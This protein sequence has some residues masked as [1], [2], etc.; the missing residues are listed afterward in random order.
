MN[1]QIVQGQ[2]DPCAGGDALD[3]H[4]RSLRAIIEGTTDAVYIKDRAGR[5]LQCNASAARFIGKRSEEVIGQD[6]R[7]LFPAPVAQMIME[8]DRLV[9]A[10]GKTVTIEETLRVGNG[11]LRTFLTTKGPM[12]DDQGQVCGLFG[13]SRDITE[14]KKAEEVL[15]EANTAVE[16]AMEGISKL[17]ET[18]HYVFVNRQYAALSGYRSEE[19]VGQSWDVTVHPDDRPAVVEAF[20]RM[21]AVGKAEGEFRGLRQDGTVFDK[22]IVIVKPQGQNEEQPGHYCFI[23]DI[24]ERRVRERQ[25]QATQ[26]LLASITRVQA[27]YIDDEKPEAVFDVILQELLKLTGSEYGFVGEVWFDKGQPVLKTHAITNIAWDHPSRELMTRSA[28]TLEFRN[29]KTLFGHVMTTGKPVIANDPAN[30]PRAGGLPPGHP[31]MHAFLGLPFSH[32]GVLTGMVGIANRSGGY[33]ESL[34][35]YLQPF[36]GTCA[37]LV[38]V[39][40]DITEQQQQEQALRESEERFRLAMQGANDG[41]W[42]WD[43]RTNEVYFSERWK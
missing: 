42:D 43:L 8:Q 17:D 24:T 7:L 23:K 36:L 12:L 34:L 21:L 19:L 3:H 25:E 22:H 28:P 6:D 15:R 33:D 20:T 11:E 5:Y 29:L 40:R 27:L 13:I 10:N 31:P 41:I 38:E 39:A 32:G 16:L 14:R 1:E 4:C 26:Q 37:Q 30:D 9:Q 18:G 35:S 2:S